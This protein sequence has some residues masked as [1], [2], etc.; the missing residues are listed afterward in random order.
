MFVIS[1]IL[2]G[3]SERV[4]WPLKH[5]FRCSHVEHLVTHFKY[6]GVPSYLLRMSL[7]AED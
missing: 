3:D 1:Y 6:T 7:E 2:L 5:L 4:E